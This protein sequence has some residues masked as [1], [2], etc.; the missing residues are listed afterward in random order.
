MTTRV[1][2]ICSDSA[3]FASS[4]A[5]SNLVPFC[6]TCYRNKTKLKSLQKGPTRG[7]SQRKKKRKKKRSISQK[8]CILPEDMSFPLRENRSYPLKKNR[9]QIGAP[10]EPSLH[11]LS[12]WSRGKGARH[13][14]GRRPTTSLQG[15]LLEHCSPSRSSATDFNLVNCDATFFPVTHLSRCSLRH[16]SKPV[17]CINA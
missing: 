6:K 11:F 7:S 15:D 4:P 17:A 10:V 8:T 1:T 3:V 2:Q 5:P 13:S 16:C 9:S 12:C 14:P